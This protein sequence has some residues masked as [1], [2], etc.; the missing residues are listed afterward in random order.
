M[1]YTKELLLRVWKSVFRH[2]VPDNDRLRSEVITWNV[3]L[4]I[5]PVKVFR[6]TLKFSKTWGLGLISLYLFIPLTISGI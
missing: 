5:H 1:N 3:L 2:S 6:D 4:H